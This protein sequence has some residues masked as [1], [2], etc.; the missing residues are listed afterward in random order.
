[1]ANMLSIM[2]KFGIEKTPHEILT[3]L[4][5]RHKTIRKQAGL[6]QSQL[7]ERSGVSFGSIKRFER[8]AQISLESFLML[9]QILNR[10]DEFD[11]ILKLQD[12]KAI[13]KLF[14]DKTRKG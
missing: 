13:D 3:E 7:A 8:T 14:S 5:I 12:T 1:L 2:K 9:T 10:L 4:A 11:L 6:S